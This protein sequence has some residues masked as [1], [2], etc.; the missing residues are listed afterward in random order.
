[1]TTSKQTHIFATRSDLESRLRDFE[2]AVAVKYIRCGLYHGPTFDQYLSLLDWSSLGTNAAGDHTTGAQFLVVRS[3]YR[4]T[5]REIPQR[6]MTSATIPALK[7]ALAI[8][9]SGKI[10][11]ISVPFDQYLDT[12]QQQRAGHN[13]ISAEPTSPSTIES[14]RY[15]VSQQGNPD[16]ITF[17]P[18]GLFDNQEVLV[19][20]HIGTVSRS[21]DSLAL[22]KAIVKSI[23]KDFVQIGSYLVGPES[24]RLMDQGYR[25]VT[26]GIGS[27]P[28]Y[29][30]R[31]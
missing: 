9:E 21:P 31:R 24:E 12:L 28:E 6:R 18:G 27:P 29:D 2:A 23:T 14:M 3:N 16:S 10:S 19:C 15:E 17:S 30:L 25:M 7:N 26:V 8:D 4:I 11:K 1:M 13:R 20:G 5:V 22:Y